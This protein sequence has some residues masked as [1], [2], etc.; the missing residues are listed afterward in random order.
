MSSEESA[1]KITEIRSGTEAPAARFT[2]FL[3]ALAAFL[4]DRAT[5][6]LIQARVDP[7]ETHPVIPGFF[8]IVHT[9]NAGAAFG[10]FAD[11]TSPLRPVFLIALAAGVMGFIVLLLLRPG[12]GGLAPT[13]VLRWGLAM[14]LGGAAGNLYDRIVRGTVTDFLEFYFGSYS[15]PAFNVA[16]TAISVGAGLLLLDMW[17]GQSRSK[18]K[19][20]PQTD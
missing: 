20:V 14:V 8:S 17:L 6:I 3:I 2:P 5:K 7:W 19:H 15:F 1:P 11:S 18:E 9:E 16:D 12:H 10:M 4:L 13:A